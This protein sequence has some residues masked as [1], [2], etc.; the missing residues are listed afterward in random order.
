MKIICVAGGSYKSFYLNY[1]INLR[2]CD[3]LIL[4]FGILYDYDMHDELMGSGV[5]T[6]EL[7]N[8]SN[9]LDTQIVAGIFVKYKNKIEKSIILCNRDKIE[10]NQISL[11]AKVIV[12]N[13]TFVVGD[14]N[15]KFNSKNKIIL[16]SKRLY[17]NLEH[18]ALNKFYVFLDKFGVT[19]VEKQKMIRKFSKYSKFVLK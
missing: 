15:T 14:E 8:L 17:P 12:K 1:V 11:G 13:K 16:S 3:L 2:K 7:I 6:K 18:C 19:F 10:L 9:K 5:V 4:N